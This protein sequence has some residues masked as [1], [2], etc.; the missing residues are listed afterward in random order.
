MDDRDHRG[1]AGAVDRVDADEL[2]QCRKWATPPHL[3]RYAEMSDSDIISEGS[4]PVRRETCELRH[5]HLTESL[6]RIEGWT[7]KHEGAHEKAVDMQRGQVRW[8]LALIVPTLLGVAGLV[9]TAV[10]DLF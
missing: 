3:D 6:S 10:S 8:L 2:D 1:G 7:S 9:L 4:R 5:E